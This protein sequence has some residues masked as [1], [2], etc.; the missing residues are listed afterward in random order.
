[1][2]A[3]LLL[4]AWI[5]GTGLAVGAETWIEVKTPN[6]TAV[7]NAGEGTVQRTASDFEQVRAAYAKVLPWAHLTQ[8]RPTVVLVLKDA[9]ALRRWAPCYF[10]KGGID[11]VSGSVAGADREYVLLRTDSLS[12]DKRV[13][14]NY[15]LYRAYLALLLSTSLE[16][17]LPLWLSSGLSDVLGNITVRDKDVLIGRPV[18]W[19]FRYFNQHGRLPLRAI[20]EARRDSPL[21]EKEDQRHL[22]ARSATCSCTTFS[23]GIAGLRSPS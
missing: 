9:V 16:R 18:P 15:N 6:L 11:A 17:R 14:T 2:H 21:V 1:V 10:V 22:F 5:G 20:L 7:S 4:L 3:G 8:A 12:D 13:T 23:S 19:E